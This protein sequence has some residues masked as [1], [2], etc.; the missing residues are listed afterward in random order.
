MKILI[1][2]G[3]GFIGSNFIRWVIRNHPQDQLVNLDLLT[4]AGKLENLEGID[5]RHYEF[6]KGDI[7]DLE[8]V[9]GLFERHGFD[10][11]VNF[12][13]ESHVDNSIKGPRVFIE[14]NVKGTMNLLDCAYRR[15]RGEEGWRERYRFLQISSDEVYGSLP[16]NDPQLKFTEETPL[17][18]SNPYSASKASAD[19]LVRAYHYTFGFPA[20]ITRCSNNYGPRQDAEKLIPLMIECALENRR[21]PLYGDG[22]NIRDWL[23]VEDHCRAVDLV[24]KEGRVG[25]IYNIGGNNE[26]RNI[27]IVKLILRLL[28]KPESLIS[29]VEDRPG[30]DRRYAMDSTKIRRELA[31]RPRYDFERGLEET[32]AWYRE[33]MVR[34]PAA[35]EKKS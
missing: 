30:H 28:G 5:T 21:L 15:W 6:F 32:V 17:R 13:A 31:W 24:L 1:T 7:A 33:G 22:R 2:G 8:T 11:V 3:C 12:A 19:V 29:Y 26:K 25:E 20:I 35:Q 18:P 16:E 10:A 27:D 23:H 14:T 9:D 4:Y 34:W